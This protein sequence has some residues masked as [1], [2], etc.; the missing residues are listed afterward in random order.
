MNVQY[1]PKVVNPAIFSAD[2][3]TLDRPSGNCWNSARA[4]ESI[5]RLALMAS[6]PWLRARLMILHDPAV[7]E[8]LRPWP[9]IYR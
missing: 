4:M 9:H 1:S 8:T 5:H 2:N 6:A 3:I 7:W